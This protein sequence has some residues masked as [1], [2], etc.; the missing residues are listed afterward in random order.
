MFVELDSVM[1]FSFSLTCFV[2]GE[3]SCSIFSSTGWPGFK[4][5][6]KNIVNN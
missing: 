4:E 1:L 2:L 6:L 3:R 5:I